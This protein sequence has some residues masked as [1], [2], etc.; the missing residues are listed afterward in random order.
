MKMIS[1]MID[2]PY[3]VRK[4]PVRVEIPVDK[5]SSLIA[6]DSYIENEP[7]TFVQKLRTGIVK[8]TDDKYYFEK[9]ADATR[10]LV[11][12]TIIVVGTHTYIVNLSIDKIK[13]LI[14]NA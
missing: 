13:E 5:I 12:S 9:Y 7:E 2:E 14:K 6:N 11:L 4:N 3:D 10:K 1:V 8:N